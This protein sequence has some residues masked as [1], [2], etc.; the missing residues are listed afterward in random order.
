MGTGHEFQPAWYEGIPSKRSYRSLFKWGAIDQFKHPNKRLF[1]LMK[2]TFNMTDDDFKKPINPGFDEV[3]YDLPSRMS[4]DTIEGL[5]AIVDG[6][7]VRTDDYTRLRVAYGKTMID[8]LRLREGIVENLP[9]AVVYPRTK[10]DIKALVSFCNER[11]IPLYIYGGGSSV[12]LGVRCAGGGVSLAMSTHMNRLLTINENNQTATVEPGIMGPDYE[13]LLNEAPKRLNSNRKYTCGHFPQSFEFS[14]VGGWIAALGSGQQSSYYGDMC[15]IVISQEYVTP[16]GT[17]K[18]LDYPATATGPKVNDILLGMKWSDPALRFKLYEGITAFDPSPCP[19][20][21]DRLEDLQAL[22]DEH[23]DKDLFHA[24]A[25]LLYPVHRVLMNCSVGRDHGERLQERLMHQRANRLADVLLQ[26]MGDFKLANKAV[27][28]AILDQGM[29]KRPNKQMREVAGRLLRGAITRLSKEERTAPWVP[30][31][32][33]WLPRLDE[34]RARPILE[35]VL[36]E[37]R[38]FFFPV[39]PGDCRGAARDALDNVE[40][41]DMELGPTP[42]EDPFLAMRAGASGGNAALDEGDEDDMT[43][44]TEPADEPVET[45]R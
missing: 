19:G 33:R 12:T 4:A 6:E 40:M 16:A 30:E 20:L 7:N 32:L 18:T 29:E 9:D 26:A 21:L 8:L 13:K 22:R 42:E 43:D 11:K 5:K 28:N 23:L 45:Q 41:P 39:W 36:N 14:T 34:K 35:T 15:D 38:F 31:A 37:R 17:I 24:P 3:A 2:Q 1:K 27:Y 25:P 44:D 10:D